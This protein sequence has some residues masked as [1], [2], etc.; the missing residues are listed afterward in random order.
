MQ[1][2]MSRIRKSITDQDRQKF[3]KLKSKVDRF[4]RGKDPDG[5]NADEGE[6]ILGQSKLGRILLRASR[7]TS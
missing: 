5:V 7:Q 1:T 4:S 2:I 6:K 3:R